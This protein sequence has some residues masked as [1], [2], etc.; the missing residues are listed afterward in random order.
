MVET[1]L[2]SQTPVLDA[3]VGVV[4]ATRPQAIPQ[5]CVERFSA[6]FTDC[7][8]V[9]LAGSGEPGPR[10]LRQTLSETDGQG[11]FGIIGS[12]R[13]SSLT[14][15]AMAN[16]C[17]AHALDFDD[18]HHPWYGHPS[19]VLVPVLLSVG[20]QAHSTGREAM[21]GYTAGLTAGHALAEVVNLEHY[22]RGWHAT[23]TIGTIAAACAAASLIGL[24]EDAVRHA[25]GIAAS[26]AGGLRANFGT[27]TKP[28]HAGLAAR[29]GILA[30]KLAGSGFEASPNALDS[31]RGFVEIFSGAATS[32]EVSRFLVDPY[33]A[34]YAGLAT[35]LYPACGATHPAITAALELGERHSG[36]AGRVR[37]I[38]CRANPLV[39]SILVYPRPRTGAEAKFSLEYSIAVSLLDGQAGLEQFSDERVARD[40]VQDLL[41]RIRVLLDPD[42]D[43]PGE[44]GVALHVITDQGKQYRHHVPLPPGKHDRPIDSADL[45]AKFLACAA[46]RLDAETAMGTLKHVRNVVSCADI[47]D[48]VTRLE[49]PTAF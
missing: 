13:K 40:D 22:R 6:A 45:D 15:A 48:I 49:A 43:P 24:G 33:R 17:A 35:K 16:G 5:D 19:A 23:A 1:L 21:A 38:T 47:G 31:E 29:N 2:D 30:A 3:L 12:Q 11:E 46:R 32:A 44:F 27:M 8:G 41:R 36:L 10:T 20:A 26:Q 34:A 37:E 39:N 42:I 9:A 28:L 4:G 7:I 25:L 18:L 14:G